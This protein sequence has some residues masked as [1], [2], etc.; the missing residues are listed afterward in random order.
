MSPRNP[1]RF[2]IGRPPDDV[3]T[4]F[5]AAA[6]AFHQAAADS[7]AYSLL[8]SKLPMNERHAASIRLAAMIATAVHYEIRSQ[9]P[10]DDPRLASAMYAGLVEGIVSGIVNSIR[11]LEYDMQSQFAADLCKGL[12]DV[13]EARQ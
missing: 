12:L 5:E 8:N 6:E 2:D 13:V 11:G 1:Q 3:L 4:R 7:A 9:P 10:P